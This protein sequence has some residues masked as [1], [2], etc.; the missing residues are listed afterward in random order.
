LKK[1][2]IKVRLN[3]LVKCSWN[4]KND[5]SKLLKKL[6]N[7]LKRNGQIE[8]IIIRELD[9][10]YY[11]IVNG[12]H[13]LD[14]FK[15][16]KYKDCMCYNLGKITESQAKRLAIETNETKF[17]HDE[18]ELS[19]LLK[20]LEEEFDID[21]LIETLPYDDIQFNEIINDPSIPSLNYDPPNENNIKLS[22]KYIVPPFSVFDTKQG[23]WQD[24][25][26]E[27]LKLI[28]QIENSRE[29]TLYRDKTKASRI[30]TA[31]CNIGTTS[32]FDPVLAEIIYTWFCP[33]NG[34]VLDP[35]G[36]EQTKGVVCGE[37][38]LNYSGI[39][40]RQEQVD[41]NNETCKKYKNIK[42]Y[43]G[44]SNNL[45]KII[46]ETDFD[47]VFT[48]PPY[49]DLEVYSADDMSSLGTY[50][51]FM[52]QYKNIFKQAISKLK[53]NSFLVV[54]IGEI[55]DKKTG[56]YRNFVGDNITIFKDLGL[57]YYNE[58]ILL[59]TL[60]TLPV[61]A[62]RFFEASK[63]VGKAHQN[64]L[65]FIKGDSKGIKKKFCNKD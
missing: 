5:D 65:V 51:E 46:K 44:D 49:Y 53:N 43:T 47:L 28:P 7:N 50:K 26:K 54:K 17:S 62:G 19:K 30:N 6:V 59:N 11:E 35:F 45:N 52:E 57:E 24:R 12:N 27:W 37:L 39:E 18:V 1:K 36:G 21:E 63:K 60:G 55:R 33:K 41:L 42:Y 32:L 22:D 13:R 31:V 25:K 3:K 64:I 48:S 15:E 34:N 29:D 8:N 20:E 40:I 14:A 10:G 38:G 9:T 61:R 23:Y 56:H 4:Y 2:F 58:I 16:L